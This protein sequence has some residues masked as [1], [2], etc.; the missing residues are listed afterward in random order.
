MQICERCRAD[1]A[2]TNAHGVGLC[3]NCARTMKVA[4]SSAPAFV[5]QAA[6]E[7]ASFI[8]P[9]SLGESAG[10]EA[11]RGNAPVDPYA[12]GKSAGQE[13]QKGGGVSEAVGKTAEAAKSVSST[14]K[15]V[16]IVGGLLGLGA[17]AFAFYRL[18][19]AQAAAQRT[20]LEHP[21]LLRALV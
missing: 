14:I 6:A 19:H 17:L 9:F 13:A 15:T 12:M 2:V 20:V 8:D 21:E 10:R 7:T 18:H 4:G 11:T 5:G 16:A 3:F 1:Q